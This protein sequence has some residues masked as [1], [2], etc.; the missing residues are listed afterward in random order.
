[1][2]RE[3]LV[4]GSSPAGLQAAID[5]ADAGIKV[6]LVEPKAFLNGENVADI[7]A[8]LLNTRLLE[9]LRHA[10]IRVCIGT[11]LTAIE[12]KDD[13]FR[14]S[15]Q[16]VPRYIDAARCTACGE[17][18]ETC[19][20][21]VPGTTH[22]AIYLDGQPGVM[23]IAKQGRAPCASTCPAGIHVQGYVALIAQGRFREAVDLIREAMPFP[24]VCG[25]VCNHQCE[26]ACT[27]GKVDEAVNI[28]ALKRFVAEW[29]YTHRQTAPAAERRSPEPTGKKVAI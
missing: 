12:Q 5:L 10:N 15:L 20:V 14:V 23:A 18:T 13:S 24:S 29:D 22:K 2:S 1:M 25:R 4:L 8:H 3:V 27:R 7:P 11:R 17:C 6:C 9:V 28:M 16:E 19:P 26:M 21:T